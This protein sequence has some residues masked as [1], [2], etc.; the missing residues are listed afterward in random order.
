MGLVGCSREG[1][2]DGEAFYEVFD[3]G[4]DFV[5]GDAAVLLQEGA[6]FGGDGGDV[7]FCADGG[8][9][10]C[11][12]VGGHG[13]EESGEIGTEVHIYYR[14]QGFRSPSIEASERRSS[15]RSI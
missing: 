4:D 9:D 1:N 2:R 7:P 13:Q 3:V 15:E 12:G 6:G 11:M 10:F 5:R 8:A 14:E